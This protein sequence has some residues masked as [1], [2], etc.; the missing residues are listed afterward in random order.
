MQQFL[1]KIW[2]ITESKV[3]LGFSLSVFR[4]LL[5]VGIAACKFH[6]QPVTRL[7]LFQ[8]L[9]DLTNTLQAKV[10]W[11]RTV[12][13]FLASDS[14]FTTQSLLIIKL[15]DTEVKGS[16]RRCVALPF[17][18]SKEMSINPPL[19]LEASLS[20]HDSG[21]WKEALAWAQSAVEKLVWAGWDNPL[22]LSWCSLA[23]VD[24][25]RMRV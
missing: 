7:L 1:R 25:C 14:C 18:S 13:T 24:R 16:F 17:K 15:F 6:F 23:H 19:P 11:T 20:F 2:K 8:E 10:S 9:G 5:V 21:G 22:S 4:S 12:G 3:A